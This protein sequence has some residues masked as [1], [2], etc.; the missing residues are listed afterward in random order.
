MHNHL[1]DIK[2]DYF[3]IL[4]SISDPI[5]CHD[6]KMNIIWMN[7]G[8]QNS[9]KVNRDS[10]IGQK[11]YKIL[12]QRDSFCLFCPAI[13]AKE[14]LSQ[15]QGEIITSD[16]NIWEI[17]GYPFIINNNE[18]A[19]SIEICRDITR[20]KKGIKAL[21][22]H[23]QKL[24]FHVDNIPMAIIEWNLNLEVT[25]WNKAAENIFEYTQEE[26]INQKALSK[27]SNINE[28]LI[29]K[30]FNKILKEKC[31][32]RSTDKNIT[33]S[34]NFIQCEWYNVPLFDE[35]N[36]II[37]IASLIQNISRRHNAQKELIQRR[38]ELKQMARNYQT[39]RQ[40]E[41]KKIAINIQD[42]LNQIMS[43][44]NFDIEKLNDEI[45]KV[46]NT[47]NPENIIES[48]NL[49][50][51]AI[52]S[53]RKITKNLELNQL[54]NFSLKTFI[55]NIAADYEKNTKNRCDLFFNTS[56]LFIENILA[57]EIIKILKIA[58]N[59]IF[60][61]LNN[62]ILKISIITERNQV[63]INFMNKDSSINHI[64]QKKE[65][66]LYLN[67]IKEI[68][69]VFKGSLKLTSDH[70]KESLEII[71]PYSSYSSLN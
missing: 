56:L 39:A 69:F 70:K 23:A 47:L 49:L 53:I 60:H 27:I 8:A 17:K 12:F 51:S 25:R 57:S 16:N 5:I 55:E 40:Q 43:L 28:S 21:I 3:H 42:D 22:E 30:F 31:E 65:M 24:Q 7:K 19:G 38:R 44:I 6:L 37:G 13:E 36:N 34:K 64:L 10:A 11:C 59:N 63:L 32:L 46:E 41:R 66:E 15:K 68:I 4:D 2:I 18:L 45:Q 54:E 14:N 58:L 9:F 29:N 20:E 71:L 61:L 33:K 48:K 26:M 62:K 67:E 50:N 35:K 52:Q 1:N